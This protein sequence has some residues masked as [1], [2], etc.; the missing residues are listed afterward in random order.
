MATITLQSL[1][2]IKKTDDAGSNDEIYLK[3]R[4]DGLEGRLPGEKSYWEM[5]DGETQAINRTYD[6]REQFTVTEMES[7]TGSD[8]V[9]GEY[10][11]V[12]QIPPP[13]SPLV[14]TGEKS[15]YELSFAYSA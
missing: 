14:F 9:V 4:T 15:E 10:T 1:K 2:C 7:D 13:G 5:G 12:V 8:D 11:F 6:F 3:L